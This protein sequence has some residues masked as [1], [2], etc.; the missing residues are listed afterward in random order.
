MP[1]PHA[2][3]SGLGA[4][5]AGSLLFLGTVALF[6]PALHCG[7]T[8]ID[9]PSYVT[10]NPHVQGGLSWADVVWAFTGRTDYWHPLT[11]LTHMLDWQ[12]YGAAPAGHHFTSV[13][14][15]A[16]NA[17]LVLLV[18]R[19]FG[20]SLAWAALAAAVFAWH[21]LRVESV[22]WVT[23]R[24]DV[25][26]GCFFLLT[27][28]AYARYAEARKD[29]Q[30]WWQSYTLT[31]TCFALGLMCK[32]MLVTLPLV[33]L[34]LDRWPLRRAATPGAWRLLLTE[35]LPL[36]ALSAAISVLTVRMQQHEN[37]F[38][39]DLPLGAR[40]GN[41]AVSL[42]R[43]LGKFFWPTDLIVCYEHPG[44]WPARVVFAAVAVVLALSWLAWR[45]RHSRPWIAAG[46]CWYLVILLPVIGLVQVGIQAMAD[47][48]TYLALLGV[49]VALGCNIAPW[50]RSTRAQFAAGAAAVGLLLGLGVRTWQQE[51]VWHDSVS[52]FE[53]AVAAS[54]HNGTAENYL[55]SA[56][57]AA[58]RLEEA[59]P[60]AERACALNPRNDSALV[61]LAG[62]RERQGRIPEAIALYRRSV[63]IKPHNP[64]A[65]ME[66]GL[67][68]FGNGHVEEARGLMTD[69]LRSTP[70]LRPR[71][72][73]IARD[74][75]THHD[76]RTAVF[77]LQ[78]L[79]ATQPDDV[80]AHVGLGYVFIQIGR[81][82][83][84]LAEWRRALELDPSYPGLREQID[85]AAATP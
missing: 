10:D 68:E 61:M 17:V 27:L 46:W 75:V 45:Q 23:E 39:L 35:K 21:P 18:V 67:L 41:A 65:Q 52:L 81:R 76:G 57:V 40:T 66:L 22:V 69:A 11:W 8:N 83:E 53:H 4:A 19:R 32:P 26:S 30:A 64:I 9:D 42:V 51:S 24:K 28:L 29:N 37:A 14:I 12:L 70:S 80:E 34:I 60:H 58:N 74:A 50:L 48:Y 1:H 20:A 63:A 7:F 13:A 72:G 47:R 79:L 77:F 43:Y 78:L 33:L 3:R 85:Q 55:A 2:V 71:T 54:P 31:L 56:L 38:V 44:Y 15:H 49:E 82:D 59:G 36:F 6:S 62:I 5:V 84:G 25:L 16:I 73:Q